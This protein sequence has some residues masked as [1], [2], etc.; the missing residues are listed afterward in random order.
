MIITQI[1]IEE[2]IKKILESLGI[3]LNLP[4][5]K[6]TPER[7]A[8]MYQDLFSGVGKEKE[9]ANIL[10]KWFPSD[11]N[12]MIVF[13]N[14][15]FSLCPHHLMPVEYDVYTAYIPKGRVIG[16]SKMTRAI[17]IL[18]KKPILQENLTTEI[19]KQ[20]MEYLKP[21]GVAT[22]IKG[23]HFCMVMRGVKQID[24]RVV[25]SD[26]RGIFEKDTATKAEFIEFTK[27][28]SFES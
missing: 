21:K 12:Q 13:R 19:N 3:D 11:V 26:M 17:E 28:N 8:R 14:K 24:S 10:Q 7:V 6:E 2:A 18:A 20:I 9:V 15:I 25:T 1:Q 22:I 23:R 27:M 4:D 16:L 5:F